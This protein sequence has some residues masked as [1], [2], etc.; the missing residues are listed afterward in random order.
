MIKPAR[1]S[2]IGTLVAIPAWFFCFCQY[3]SIK[4][5]DINTAGMAAY[6]GILSVVGIPFAFIISSLVAPF[7]S[8]LSNKSRVGSFFIITGFHAVLLVCV[9]LLYIYL[10][11]ETLDW[12]NYLI[13]PFY[14]LLFLIPPSF[15]GCMVYSMLS[16]KETLRS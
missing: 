7:L 6:M 5:G 12:I 2:V 16:N 15:V 14:L 10:S 13:L 4:E 3:W 1:W 8:K 11:S 9:D